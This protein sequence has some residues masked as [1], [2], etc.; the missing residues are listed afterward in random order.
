MKRNIALIGLSVVLFSGCAIVKQ[1]AES[2]TVGTNGVPVTF[3][4]TSTIMATGDAKAVVDKVRA[5]SGKTASVGA[6]G[7]AEETS[8]SGVVTNGVSAMLYLLTH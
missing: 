6:S 2:T 3:K 4:A 8:G 1:T 7:V 5:S